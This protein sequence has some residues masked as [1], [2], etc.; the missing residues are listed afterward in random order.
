MLNFKCNLQISF[1]RW[2]G[3][4]FIEDNINLFLDPNKSFNSPFKVGPEGNEII[5]GRYTPSMDTIA[6]LVNTEGFKFENLA[7]DVF[8]TKD[9]LEKAVQI[10]EF[11]GHVTFTKMSSFWTQLFIINFY[12]RV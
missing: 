11:W 10:H 7:K 8:G 1:L 9:P 3:G 6:L 5:L 12:L 2:Y 4:I